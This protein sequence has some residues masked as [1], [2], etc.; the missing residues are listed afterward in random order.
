LVLAAAD[1]A[2]ATQ[3]RFQAPQWLAPLNTAAKQQHIDG[4]AQIE[5]RVVPPPTKP[6]KRL[7]APRTLSEATRAHLRTVA[8]HI[9]DPQ[10]A[11][12]LRR[13]AQQKT[14]AGTIN[15]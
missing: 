11:D 3:A 14:P 15:S 5:V 8:E 9:D 7:C 2:A 12:V 4:V 1:S 6:T 10:L 13:L